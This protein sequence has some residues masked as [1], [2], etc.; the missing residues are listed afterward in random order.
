MV[1]P[2]DY[3]T[4]ADLDALLSGLTEMEAR[5]NK[6]IDGVEKRVTDIEDE[7]KKATRALRG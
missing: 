1:T 2:H 6:R 7:L 4:K 3:L 5:L